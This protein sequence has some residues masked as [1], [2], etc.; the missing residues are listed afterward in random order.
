MLNKVLKNNTLLITFET[1]AEHQHIYQLINH[2]KI[3]DRK[4]K[5]P[6]GSVWVFSPNCSSTL[7]NGNSLIVAA[8]AKDVVVL[9]YQEALF[10]FEEAAG[11]ELLY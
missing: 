2:K 11:V 8:R 5:A 3:E 9:D 6:Y 1:E 4:T 7:S 10:L